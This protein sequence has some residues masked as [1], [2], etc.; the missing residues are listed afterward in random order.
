[1]FFVYTGAGGTTLLP[2]GNGDDIGGNRLP[3]GSI[4]LHQ[5]HG[6]AE[7]PDQ[8][9]DLDP[10]VDIDVVQRLVP[11]IQVRLYGG[12]EGSVCMDPIPKAK[13]C[14]DTKCTPSNLNTLR[15][16]NPR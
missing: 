10:G 11:D 9:L 15:Y 1:M 8:I 16:E 2:V 13:A 5:D 7:L 6:G 14:S 12:L 3:E 4:M